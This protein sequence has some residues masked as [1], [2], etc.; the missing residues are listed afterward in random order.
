[1]PRY[2]LK[3]LATVLVLSILAIAASVTGGFAAPATKY[4]V[5]V[6]VPSLAA[7]ADIAR[8]GFDVAGVNQKDLTVAWSPPPRTSTA[9][10]SSGTAM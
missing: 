6:R 2:G 8:A 3:R 1:M 4:F 9:S 7:A 5:H 10:A